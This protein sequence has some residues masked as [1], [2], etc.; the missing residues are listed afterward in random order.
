M[1]NYKAGSCSIGGLQTARSQ[2]TSKGL[3][4]SPEYALHLVV[5]TPIVSRHYPKS[6]AELLAWFRT[7]ADCRDYLDWLRWPDGFVCP[8]CSAADGWRIGDGRWMCAVCS[9]R[10]STTAGTIFQ[11]T[12]TPLTVWFAAAWNLTTQKNG[13]SALGLQ[14]VLGLGSY[15]TAWMMLHRFRTAMVR[16]GRELLA[17]DVEVDETFIGGVKSGKRGRGS[18]GKVLVA[19]A[20]ERLVSGGFGRARM[21]VIS[22]ATAPTLRAFLLENV[23]RG[24]VVLSDGLKSYPIAVGGDFTHKSFN[25]AGSGVPAHIPL[26][27]VHRVA[28]LTKRWLLGTHQGAVEVDHLQAYLN[29]FCFRF[30]RRHSRS[31]GMLFFRLMQQSV[32]APPVTYRQL[33]VNP[34]SKRSQPP[35]PRKALHSPCSLELPPAGRPWRRP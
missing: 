33:V 20:V 10:T 23:E 30:N 25:V 31:R 11:D 14:R 18:A 9:K 21:T 17:G 19:I 24:S 7:D 29:E 13:I 1:S 22:D 26:P 2:N 5:D 16:P 15:Q 28:S 8:D 4:I 27:G 32:D 34:A 6:Y 12:R 3:S 35:N